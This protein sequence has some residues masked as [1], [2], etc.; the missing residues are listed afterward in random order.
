MKRAEILAANKNFLE[1]ANIFYR[2]NRL[3]DKKQMGE[4]FKVMHLY[5]K[6]QK[7]NLGF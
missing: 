2:V 5:K 6:N 1:K 7:F 4:L 3:V